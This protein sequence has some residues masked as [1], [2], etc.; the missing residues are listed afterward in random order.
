[1]LN[2]NRYIRYALT[3]LGLGCQILKY[4]GQDLNFI[5]WMN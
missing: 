5:M 1:M 3:G 4:I 2:L